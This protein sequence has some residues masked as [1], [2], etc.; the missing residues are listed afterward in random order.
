MKKYISYFKLRF[1]T[2]LQ[3][4]TSAIAGIFTQF[5][6]AIMEI[7][8]YMAFYKNG[9]ETNI[10]LKQVISYVWLRQAFYSLINDVTD[11]EI[12]LSVEKG[13]IAYELIKPINL[14]WI[15]LS[16]TVS[17]RT[18][19][20][21]LKCI[22]I[23]I[24]APLLPGGMN[25]SGPASILSLGLFVFTLFMGLFIMSAVV[26]LFYISL[27]YTM[28]SKGTTSIFYA[29]LSFFGGSLIPIPL[30]PRIWQKICYLLPFSLA[31]DLPFRI[32]SGNINVLEGVKFVG[33]Q[34]VWVAI[35]IIMGNLL[36][37]R[38][39]KKVVIQGG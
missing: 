4:R 8:I 20:C 28:T 36:L 33:I 35:L 11:N 25:L 1:N 3:Y 2:A 17:S 29:L 13:N 19:S 10:S 6:W 30:M 7:L 22:P 34:F 15:W 24:I 26:N 12:K 21:F 14:Y 23:L 18:A 9:V 27:F 16:K 32:Y 37:N 5:F 38:I 31:I 39:L